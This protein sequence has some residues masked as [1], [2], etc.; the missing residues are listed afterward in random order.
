MCG[1]AGHVGPKVIPGERIDECLRLMHRRG[2][3]HAAH[4]RFS[5][6]GRNTDLL[7]G[8]L[9]IIDFDD[10]SNQPFHVGSTWMVYNGEL[11]DYLELR[12]ELLARG[13]EMRTASDTEVMLRT[14]QYLGWDWLDRCEGMWAFAVYDESNRSLVLCRD[15][16]GE[17][18]LY[19]YQEGPDLYFGSE[20]K[21][22]VA[23]RGHPLKVNQD[24][25]RRY[26]VNGYK[27]L[28]KGRETFFE[29][30]R[31]LPP[32]TMLR[33][34]ADGRTDER[35]YWRPEL[36][37]DEGMRYEDAVRGTRDRLI[38]SVELRLR[39]DTP[40][41]FCMSGG[42]DSNALVAIAKRVFSYDVHGFTIINGDER[43]DE[44]ALVKQAVAELGV[45]HTSVTLSTAS[46]LERLRT[47][48]R[49]HDA[50]VYT[51]TYY[52]HWLLMEEIARAGYR[53]SVSGSAADELFTGY[54]DHHLFY[55]AEMHGRPGHAEALA[56]WTEHVR[57]VVRNPHLQDPDRFVREPG[58]RDH[59]YFES[60]EFSR[61]LRTPWSEAFTEERYT[62][63]L[64]R[65]RTLNELFH[66][67]IP[68][69]LHEDDLNAMYYSIENRSPFLDRELFEFA[70]SIPARHLMQRGYAKAVLRDAVRGIVP[71]VIV[72]NHR[73]VGFNAP[74]GA[75]LDTADPA[76]RGALLDESPIFELVRR[77]AIER[78]IDHGV[79]ELPNSRSKFLFSFLSAKM[80]LEEFGS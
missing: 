29:G 13:A 17:K 61:L 28:Y 72:D 51:I 46:F 74:I 24:Q 38:R 54:F 35:T 42:M 26:L 4:R 37:V 49:Y 56:A 41:A 65:D 33:I 40:L 34:D 2:P 25:L 69:I 11:Y 1:I 14:T 50:P 9:K 31:E 39:A 53:I 78:L 76:V 8:R 48:V 64:L 44:E 15:R 12:K 70:A 52:A 5:R 77:E 21:D 66:E 59:V 73:K 68:V 16:F 22:I 57:P 80:F 7:Y 36:S 6:D 45:R 20:V 58:F 75:L 3:D 60:A 55:L 30:L 18:P 79:R 27:A 32:A 43:Y 23:L 47:L 10:R 67:A 71:D 19:L 63:V 62:G